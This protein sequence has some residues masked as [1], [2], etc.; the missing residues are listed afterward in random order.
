[1][2]RSIL[3]IGVCAALGACSGDHRASAPDTGALVVHV[4]AGPE[5]LAGKAVELL[6]TGESRVTDSAGL[7]RFALPPGGYTVR[8][9][10][11]TG[12]G[13]GPGYVDTDVTI[14]SGETV[15]V[16]IQDCPDCAGL[17]GGR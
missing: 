9:H 15:R 16:D 8:V 10:A 14:D 1:M 2:L 13:P 5:G 6:G 11:I 3:L 7:A 12:P 4:H 17:Q